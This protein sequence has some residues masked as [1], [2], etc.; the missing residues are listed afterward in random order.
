MAPPHNT[1]TRAAERRKQRRQRR[2]TE[3]GTGAQRPASTPKMAPLTLSDRKRG[4][5]SVA[6]TA[7]MLDPEVEYRFVRRDLWR[8]VIYTAICFVLMMIVLYIL[9]G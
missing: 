8:L 3:Q 5:R 9:E 7:Q 1:N 4:P 2:R 6:A